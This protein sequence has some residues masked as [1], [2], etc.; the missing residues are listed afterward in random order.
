MPQGIV[1]DLGAIKDGPD[2]QGFRDAQARLNAALGTVVEF[3][4]PI[5]TQWPPGTKLDP[6]TGRPLDPTI[7]PTGGGG[8]S[9]VEVRVTVAE[10]QVQDSS[11]DVETGPSGVRRDETPVFIVLES[12]FDL[13]D[14]ATRVRWLGE[15]YAITEVNPDGIGSVMRYLVF[16]EAT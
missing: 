14:G 4:A 9:E 3:L 1:P 12:D 10:P 15:T 7:K 6:E 5:A 2:L 8:F 13:I 16:T 11:S